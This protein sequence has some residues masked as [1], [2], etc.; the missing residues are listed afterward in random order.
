MV[1]S[2]PKLYAMQRID[3]AIKSAKTM[4]Y[5]L[6]HAN[7]SI[8]YNRMSAYQ[9]QPLPVYPFKHRCHAINIGLRFER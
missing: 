9:V 4:N 1:A 2:I 6:V 3:Q 5:Y 8:R 7:A